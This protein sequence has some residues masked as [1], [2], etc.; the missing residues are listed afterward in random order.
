MVGRD[1]EVKSKCVNHLPRPYARLHG[2]FF[3]FLIPA[4]VLDVKYSHHV[5][6]IFRIW[7]DL[8]IDWI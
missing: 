4:M 2:T 1:F 8:L 6:E 3:H 5:E 7:Q